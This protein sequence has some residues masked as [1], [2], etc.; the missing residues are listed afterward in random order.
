M[1]RAFILNQQIDYG[2]KNRISLAVIDSHFS[3]SPYLKHA[4][5]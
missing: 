5:V 2:C 4:S 1:L 3:G